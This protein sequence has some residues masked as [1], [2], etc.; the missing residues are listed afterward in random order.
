MSESRS[1]PSAQLFVPFYSMDY[2]YTLSPANDMTQVII[3]E[4]QDDRVLQEFNEFFS[5]D[6]MARNLGKR[7]YC[8]C[9]GDLTAREGRRSFTVR[10][11]RLFAE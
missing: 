9:V 10:E 2:G 7:V 1:I 5:N 6:S 3:A 4:F 11:A 8:E